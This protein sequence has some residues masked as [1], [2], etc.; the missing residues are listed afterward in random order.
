MYRSS[1]KLS[2]EMPDTRIIPDRR[3]FS[4]NRT[5]TQEELASYQ[6]AYREAK[7]DQFQVI[8]H[9][10]KLPKS[11]VEDSSDPKKFALLRAESF[12]DTFGKTAQRRKPVLDAC[13]VHSLIQQA[14]EREDDFATSQARLQST[15]GDGAAE[16]DMGTTRR[17]LGEVYKVID[18]STVVVEVLD[19]F[20]QAGRVHGA[21]NAAQASDLSDQ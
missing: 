16:A 13:D 12:Q 2:H 5:I 17:I 7:A 4:N 19:A 11:L 18:S 21:G 8:L 20:A 14:Q 6:N 3:W 1:G 10:R 15:D 9:E